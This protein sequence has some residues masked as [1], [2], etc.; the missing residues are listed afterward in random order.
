MTPVR[1]GPKF[2]ASQQEAI[3]YRAMDA[4][5]VAGPGSGKTTVLVERFRR[6]IEDHRFDVREILA[7]TF[8]EKAAANMKAKLAE[9]FAHD[10]LR[11]RDLE[12]AWV[13]TIHGFCARLLKENA[14]AAGIDPR[15]SVLDARESDDMQ[16]ECLNAAL[17][18]LV[19]ERREAALELIGILQTPWI[20]GDLKSSYDGMRS[21]GKTVEE[22]RAMP[23]PLAAVTPSGAAF[24][25]RRLLSLWPPRLQLTDA[26]R[27]QQ[28]ELLE[29]AQRM[30]E[31][32]D[33]PLPE[34]LKLIK[35]CPLH[36]GR[37]AD[38]VKTEMAAYK[39][40]L[41]K[42]AA[43]V[44]DSHTARY[45]T[46]VFDILTRFD[47]LYNERKARA[48]VLDFNDLERRSI[49]LLRRDKTVR[50]RVRAQFR[51]IM[52]DEFQDINE[53]QAELIRLIRG[54]DVFFAVGDVN[55]SIY[56]FRHAQ[57][58]IFHRYR[59]EVEDAGKHSTGLLHNFRSRAEILS[60]VEALLNS[61]QGIEAREL[62]AGAS[63]REKSG[64]SIEVFR[65]V[66]EDKDEASLREARWIAH[67]ILQLRGE[68]EIGP[69]EKPARAD[70]G[71][72]AVLCRNS[73]SMK[74]ILDEF[75]RAKIPYV[76][77]RRQSFLLSREGLDISALLRVIANP[78][79]GVALGTLLRSTLVGLSDEALLRLK[80]NGNAVGAGLRQP[81][82]G[83]SE[84]DTRRIE[85]FNAGL[86]RWRAG[87]Q[88][89]P[90]D[91]LISRALSDCGF[92]W[93]PG[94]LAGINVEAFLH[95]AR[96][97]GN[98][99]SLLDFLRELES[100][101]G[102]VSAESELSDADQG[103]CVQVMTAH[104]AK[105]LE[106]PVTIIAGME[107]GTQR[108]SAAITFTAE[109]GLGIKWKDP[110]SDDGLKDSWALANSEY[111]KKREKD[112]MA[113]LLYVAM[114]RA[115]E[116][117]ILSYSA[118]KQRAGGW[119]K[120]VED[121]FGARVRIL[122]EDPPVLT[123]D[124]AS[125][126]ERAEVMV[127]PRPVPRDQHDTAVNVTSLA[128][129][130]NCA[131]KYYLQ[132]YV[133]WTSGRPARFDPEAV[134]RVDDDGVSAAELGSLVHEVLAGKTG[135]YP[136]EAHQLA[137]VF[138]TSELGQR[139]ASAVR[140]E[141]EWDFIADIDGTLVRGSIDLWFE[142]TDTGICLVDYKTDAPPVRPAD[143]APQLA[144]YALAVE[145]AFGVRPEKAYLHFLRP[146]L[147]AEV[148]LDPE[149]LAQARD[150]I[151]RLRDAQNSLRFDLNEGEHCKTCPYYRSL[152]P[153]TV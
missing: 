127:L 78:R 92:E 131:R 20:Q 5:V 113:R 19:A 2:T 83:F 25:L 126:R 55:Q 17:D 50:E 22:T 79:D 29:W 140:A 36:L 143:Y 118:G 42:F 11:L 49:E 65:A 152:C 73:E 93:T 34:L 59:K 62:V 39:E 51:Q 136:P 45:R 102:A 13:S 60:C 94:S 81:L 41:P 110:F 28:D 86:M 114:T 98:D 33:A 132:R 97:R 138:L 32:D 141:R 3:E 148:Q 139:A 40:N 130:A 64:S 38:S 16:A 87:Q 7:I 10:P 72:F 117:L 121:Y 30:A 129:F 99:R 4:C 137:D 125:P 107:K 116:H 21:A 48:G 63:F 123:A 52:L 91:V 75:D 128:L 14:I 112:E 104:A 31:A 108:S 67:R 142:E 18:E 111:L 103:N 8:T 149:T 76:C 57:P 12:S 115:E 71:D 6:L 100:I 119:A 90:L 43:A 56:G 133:G 144:I 106:F 1:S 147:I 47:A 23:S 150:L 124:A 96:T 24:E 9:K 68:L 84:A 37:V 26:R 54:E 46:L 120:W 135:E 146:N 15:F 85:R 61:T 101:E 122:E 77:G 58:E 44:T 66:H 153:S 109:F 95:L 70:F 69:P 105:G 134:A 88:I 80:L 145:R 151:A 35:A 27:R 74:P 53:Q 89:V 82:T